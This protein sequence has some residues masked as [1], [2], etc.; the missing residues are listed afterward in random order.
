MKLLLSG[1][2]FPDEFPL[3]SIVDTVD[4]LDALDQRRV[5]ADEAGIGFVP[6]ER[7]EESQSSDDSGDE[8][9]DNKEAASGASMEAVFG[10]EQNK[11]LRILMK[12]LAKDEDDDVRAEALVE[13]ARRQSRRCRS[14]GAGGRA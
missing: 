12:K 5:V 14:A 8:E 13:R 1:L 2:S 9:A 3:G 4:A 11:S 7:L 10:R 6:V